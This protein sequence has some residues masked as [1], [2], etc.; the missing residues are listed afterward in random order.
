M[1]LYFVLTIVKYRLSDKLWYF[2]Y[3]LKFINIK[4]VNYEITNF[5]D[6]LVMSKPSL[7]A[8]M[9]CRFPGMN[10]RFDIYRYFLEYMYCENY[11]SNRISRGADMFIDY[12][13]SF[14]KTSFEGII[15]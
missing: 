6:K 5:Q 1:K 15:L 9:K 7:T 8:Y 11:P 4:L 12:S 3:S 2:N 13:F 14:V 10:A